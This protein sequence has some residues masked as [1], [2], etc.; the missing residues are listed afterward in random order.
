MSGSESHGRRVTFELDNV[1]GGGD[2]VDARSVAADSE[3][4]IVVLLR[5]HY[6]PHS[7]ELVRTLRNHYGVF[8]PLRE[9][10]DSLPA[11][12]LCSCHSDGLRVVEMLSEP[13][14]TVGTVT[15]PSRQLPSEADGVERFGGLSRGAQILACAARVV[16]FG[17]PLCEAMDRLGEQRLRGSEFR[18]LPS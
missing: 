12:G 9:A 16:G 11:V 2:V 13:V 4:T 5:G 8:E 14:S 17:G 18:T 10:S 15:G 6:C 3:H 1:G 7:R